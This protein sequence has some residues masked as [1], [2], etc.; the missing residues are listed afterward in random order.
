M[1]SNSGNVKQER[2]NN[3]LS[4]SSQEELAQQNTRRI[5][6]LTPAELSR[7]TNIQRIQQKKTQVKALPKNKKLE[8]LAVY[9]KCKVKQCPKNSFQG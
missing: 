8:K 1:A 5:V 3:S 7:P 4:D 6:P 9:S 2:Q